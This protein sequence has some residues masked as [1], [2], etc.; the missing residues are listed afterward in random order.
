MII[1][2]LLIEKILLKMAYR[3]PGYS[4]TLKSLQ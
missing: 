3:F 1:L 2:S 4:G